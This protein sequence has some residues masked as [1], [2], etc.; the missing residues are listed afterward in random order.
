MDYDELRELIRED[1][2]GELANILNSNENHHLFNVLQIPKKIPHARI[3][4]PS[5]TP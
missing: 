2:V 4:R 1:K 3:Q 5:Q